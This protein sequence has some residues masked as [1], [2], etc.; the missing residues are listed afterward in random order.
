MM[1]SNTELGVPETLITPDP[2]TGFAL[3]AT[4]QGPV[5]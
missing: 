2:E 1:H 3:A 5:E 4:G